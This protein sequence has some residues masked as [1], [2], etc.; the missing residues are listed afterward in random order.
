MSYTLFLNVVAMLL[1]GV[2][3]T[4]GI[5]T[6]FPYGGVSTLIIGGH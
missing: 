1:V 6:R 2:F 3:S 4:C 5:V